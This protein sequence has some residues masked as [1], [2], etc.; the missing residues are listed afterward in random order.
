MTERDWFIFTLWSQ[1][2]IRTDF[3]C[4]N[5]PC[6]NNPIHSPYS[7][8]KT[9]LNNGRDPKPKKTHKKTPYHH[10]DSPHFLFDENMDSNIIIVIMKHAT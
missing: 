1:V 8:F 2:A 7:L 3:P 9:L 4:D 5:V 6:D 10:S